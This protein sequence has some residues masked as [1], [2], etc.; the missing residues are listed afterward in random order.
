[1]DYDL[2]TPDLNLTDLESVQEQLIQ[3]QRTVI[4]CTI[5]IVVSFLIFFPPIIYLYIRKLEKGIWVVKEQNDN[6][7]SY[8]NQIADEENSKTIV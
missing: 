2:P 4:F 8:Y 6:L 3:M 1:M 7:L 5:C